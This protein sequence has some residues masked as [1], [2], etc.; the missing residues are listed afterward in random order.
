MKETPSKRGYRS[1]QATPLFLLLAF[2]FFSAFGQQRTI[3][4]QV[5]DANGTPLPAVNV[6]V[7]G[8]TIGTSADFDGNYSLQVPE[9]ANTLVFSYLGFADKEVV[10]DGRTTID[11]TLDESTAKLDEVV[12]IGYGTRNREDLT[13]AV[14][15][16]QAK[17]IEEQ[18]ITTFEQ[19]L[20]GQVSGV[21]LRQNGAPG[22]GP[23]ILIRGVASTGDNNA[24]LYVVDGI[25]LGNV[26]S[27]RDNF[28][29]SSIDPNSIESISVLKDA[30]AKAIYGSRASN[31]VVVIT[32]KR[33]KV[34]KPTITF[35]TSTGF[36][37]VPEF[38]QPDVLNAEELRRY[39]IEFFEDRLF[40]TGA[41]GQSE[42]ADLD[43]L[44]TLGDL[45]EGTNWFDEITRSAPISEYNI[46][47]NGGTENVRYNISTNYTNQDGTLINTNFKRY[48]IRAN[49]DVNV[50]DNIRF[51]LNLAPTQTIATGGRTDAGRDNFNIFSA[52][53]LSRWTD[54][55]APVFDENGELTNVALGDVIPFYNVNPVYLLTAREDNRRTNQVLAGSF[56]EVDILEGLTARTFGSIQYTDRRNT[57]FEPSD[58]PGD[59]A[60]TP[61]LLGTRQA[62]ASISEFTNFNWIWENTLTYSTTISDDH[63]IDVLA[64]FT[65]ENR[66]FDNTI[67]N[68]VNIIDESIRIPDSDNVDPENVNNFTGRGAAGENSLVSI[69]GRLDYAYKNKYYVT[70]TIRRDGSSRFGA[71]TRYGNFPSVAAAWRISNEPFWES[72]KSTISE[73]KLEGGYGISGSN[74]NIGDFQA[75]G[76]INPSD[77]NASNPDYVFDG[78]IA[79]GSAVTAL[80]NSLLTWE[81]AKELNLGLDLGFLNDKIFLGI[82]YYDIE[83]EGF[84]SDLPLPRT[85]GFGNILT[86]LGSIENKGFEVE[87]RLSNVFN[88]K[89]FQWD[90][91]FNFTRNR[92]KVLDLAA[93]AGFIRRGAIAR[94]FTET[95]IGEQVG[96]YRGFNV[97][98][99]FT[100][101]EID[102]PNVPKYPGA[103]EGSL[104]YEDGNG[105]GVLGDQEDFVIIGNPNP[106]FI[107]G[108]VHNFRYKDLDLSVIFAGAVGQQIFNGTNQYNGNQ[109][110]VFNVDRRQLN[111]WRPGDDPTTKTIPGTASDLSRQRFR[112]PNS[113]SVDD[114]DYLWV[115]N[116]TLG[117]NFNG[118]ELGNF[119]KNAR[120]YTS[121]QNPFL[122]TEYDMGNPEIN[123]SAD[124][125]LVRN[126]NYGAYPIS[127]IYT[128][129]VNVTF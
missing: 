22:G 64:G 115:R 74:A 126:V 4:G 21:Q 27:Q 94:Q 50:T 95:A 41:L 99:L 97:T 67:I 56:I 28:V 123:R 86:N 61:N 118:K 114:A 81:E 79:A 43:R 13:G 93:E 119:F 55:S 77:P 100:Q 11:I 92:S 52:V 63:R 120:I 82:D 110:G 111:R 103:V 78:N 60:L 9:D 91:N 125:A 2:G 113:L 10:I 69:I 35:G 42:I 46:G 12:V 105:D 71:N 65:M 66:R 6:I 75:Q 51:G 59:G 8:T 29:L 17:G 124:T 14:S 44:I 24:P 54:P 101:A 1:F 53:P 122:F 72:I 107:Y 83:T 128:L 106:D 80:P 15:T 117:Y 40:A 76:R 108:M 37:T 57:S 25:P 109:D 45:G 5:T 18:P 48:S 70:G 112:L 26:N 16:I 87:L 98:G 88:G 116:I 68:A 34:G 19:A 85:S 7:K 73:F 121:I 20:S 31:G 30:S 84:I 96:L 49:I 62:R 33:G 3:S 129:G 58:F 39:R 23:E 32:T 47:I 89:D 127:R 38:E 36:Q 90:A 102:D 104:K